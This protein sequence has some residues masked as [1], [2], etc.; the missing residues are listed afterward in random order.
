MR[1]EALRACP[2][3]GGESFRRVLEGLDFD[4]GT[5]RYRIDQCDRCRLRFTN[6]RP[7]PEDVPLLY[8]DRSF[9]T[10]PGQGTPLGRVRRA[11][12][13]RRLRSIAKRLGAGRARASDVGTGD[14]FFALVAAGM[15]WCG[16]MTAVDFFPQPPPGLR[17]A[18]AAGEIDYHGLDAYLADD[19]KYDVVFARFVLE[20][21]RDPREFLSAL[22]RKLAPRGTLVIEVPN[23]RSLWRKLFGRYYSELS[24][25]A[26][27]FH[28]DPSALEG[29]LSGFDCEI[30]ED[31]HGVVLAKSLGNA[32][33]R[34]VARTGLLAMTALGIELAADTLV[35][36]PANMTVLATKRE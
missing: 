29:L 21:V 35:G 26:H 2:G 36:P 14:G 4:F 19:A 30:R 24:L 33:G 12:L 13:E 6:P 31:V 15:P 25:P 28:Y 9:E 27:T 22:G 18:I 3:C 34:R 17:A 11:R 5:G 23:W 8:E 20:H 7:I 10:L 16:H 32:L 1:T